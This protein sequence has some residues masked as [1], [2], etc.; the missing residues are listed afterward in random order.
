MNGPGTAYVIEQ[1]GQALARAEQQN[2]GLHAA[3]AAAQEEQRK[4]ESIVNVLGDGD[5]TV[6]GVLVRVR[7]IGESH[8]EVTVGED[9][10]ASVVP[11]KIPL[12]TA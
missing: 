4:A 5:L 1:L 3:L 11:L 9:E 2:A 12:A 7:H 6:N 10:A 8:F